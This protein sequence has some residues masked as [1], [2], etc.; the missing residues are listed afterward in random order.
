MVYLSKKKLKLNKYINKHSY[1]FITL[2][3]ILFRKCTNS[4]LYFLAIHLVSTTLYRINPQRHDQRQVQK[5]FMGKGNPRQINTH[6]SYKLEL[7]FMFM[8]YTRLNR[9]DQK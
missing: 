1:N 9:S 8:E 7:D 2:H 3:D 4:D 5:C 6:R